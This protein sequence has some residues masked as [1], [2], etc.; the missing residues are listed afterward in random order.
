MVVRVGK[1]IVAN[2][3]LKL[4]SLGLAAMSW[5]LVSAAGIQEVEV[6]GVPVEIVV[7][8]GLAVWKVSRS[9]LRVKLKGPRV[10]LSAVGSRDLRAQYVVPDDTLVEGEKRLKIDCR[11]Q[12]VFSMPVGVRLTDVEPSNIK[13]DLVP[14]MRARVRVTALFEGNVRAGYEISGVR[15]VPARVSVMGPEPIVKDLAEVE[16]TPINCDGRLESFSQ[17]VTIQN[18]RGE[19]ELEISEA[20]DV[21]V[22][23]GEQLGT[24]VL[25]GLHINLLGS[26]E[27]LRDVTI[28][29]ETVDVT[30]K[31][32]KQ[33][34]A[35]LTKGQV[36]PYVHIGKKGKYRLPVE[37]NVDLPG[38][39]VIGDLPSIEV[40]VRR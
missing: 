2:W 12:L 36:M 32:Q 38:V 37:V 23:I 24:R 28:V 40:T 13:V 7:P 31:G 8:E 11:E 17:R 4:M 33:V 10:E 21:K 25:K 5:F 29:P 9:Q 30:V 6:D 18:R 22:S 27:M 19:H 1:A 35:M 15:V 39:Y 26:S 14:K 20:V 3:H 34:L 16:T